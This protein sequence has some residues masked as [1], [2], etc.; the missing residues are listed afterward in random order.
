MS[1]SPKRGNAA[2]NTLDLL[3]TLLAC[4]WRPCD[5]RLHSPTEP[6]SPASRISLCHDHRDHARSRP[7]TDRTATVENTETENCLVQRIRC[8]RT[9]T[10]CTTTATTIPLLLASAA[11]TGPARRRA[12]RSQ[13]TVGP[14][15]Q[16]HSPATLD[17]TPSLR[18]GLVFGV[19]AGERH[20]QRKQ[21]TRLVPLD[22]YPPNLDF[23]PSSSHRRR[24]FL[25]SPRRQRRHHSRSFSHRVA[26]LGRFLGL[27]TSRPD[28]CTVTTTDPST[29][30]R[31]ERVRLRNRNRDR[32]EMLCSRRRTRF[33]LFSRLRLRFALPVCSTTSDTLSLPPNP[34]PRI[35]TN[36]VRIDH[37]DVHEFRLAASQDAR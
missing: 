35:G 11:A 10:R 21:T 12:Y 20:R 17:R 36:P 9:R 18:R 6:D 1:L 8:T 15:P 23:A 29:S 14:D 37:G 13:A 30:D 34:P 28:C 19:V 33:R 5:P 31:R 24:R 16:P 22:L 2:R 25:D 7:S 4:P 26:G 27:D 3:I 32:E